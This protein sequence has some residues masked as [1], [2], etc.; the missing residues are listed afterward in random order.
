MLLLNLTGTVTLGLEGQGEEEGG[1][2]GQVLQQNKMLPRPQ[3]K[4][5]QRPTRCEHRLLRRR[6]GITTEA[7]V[8]PHLSCTAEWPVAVAVAVAVEEE[9]HPTRSTW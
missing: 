4:L 7:V 2:E 8:P 9:T 5:W 6:Q 3:H 1:K